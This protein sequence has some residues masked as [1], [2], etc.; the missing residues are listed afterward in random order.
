MLYIKARPSE[1]YDAFADRMAKTAKATNQTILGEFN[2]H[3]FEA[4]PGMDRRDILKEF[5][6]NGWR[7]YFG[8]NR[9]AEENAA[10]LH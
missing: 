5:H 9:L 3:T 2:Q 7:D 10:K 6:E 8:D 4:R 1:T